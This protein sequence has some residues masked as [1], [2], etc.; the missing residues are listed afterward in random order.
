MNARELADTLDKLIHLKIQMAK[1]K[2]DYGYYSFK[3]EE[4]KELILRDIA[5]AF[6]L[7]VTNP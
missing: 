4:D 3:D 7:G 2:E 6:R 5:D 1:D